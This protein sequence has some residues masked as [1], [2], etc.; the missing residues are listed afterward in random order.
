MIRY[1]SGRTPGE[2]QF[3]APASQVLASLAK[4]L[5]NHPLR[6]VI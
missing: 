2:L 5:K 6:L 4:M 3:V 1:S